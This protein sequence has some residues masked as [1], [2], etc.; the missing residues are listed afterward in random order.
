MIIS[1]CLTYTILSRIHTKENLYLLNPLQKNN[2][3]VDVMIKEE[4]NAKYEL[5]IAMLNFFSKILSNY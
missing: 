5:S 4:T 2:F 3:N 1:T